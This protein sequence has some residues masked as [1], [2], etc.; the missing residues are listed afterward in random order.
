MNIQFSKYSDLELI[1]ALKSG[2]KDAELAFAEIYSR[3]SQRIYA[4][5]LRVTGSHEEAKDIFQEC[6][7]KF[8]NSVNG[9][10]KMD[11][12]PAYLIKISRN[13]ALNLQ[14][15]QQVNIR[16]EDYNVSVN[17]SGYEQR[18]MMD[19]IAKALDL[20][21]FDFREAFV[22]RMYQGLS[23]NEIS[24]IVGVGADII[25]NRVWR[26][27]EKIKVILDPYLKEMDKVFDMNEDLDKPKIMLKK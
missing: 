18:E 7:L 11:N 14:R 27:K 4:Y 24:E 12:L 17:D 25:R 26:A 20:L 23:Y 8:Y 6:F 1:L 5:C 15:D 22:M 9:I 19:L 13:I 21:N 2:K 10:E 3:Y 16:I